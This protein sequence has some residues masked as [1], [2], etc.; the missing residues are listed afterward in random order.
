MSGARNASLIRAL[1]R[2]RF[3]LMPMEGA[4]GRA[5]GRPLRG[6]ESRHKL[7][8]DAGIEGT[9]LLG[10]ELLD[11]GFEI[12]PHLAARLVTDSAHLEEIVRW[13]E[14]LNV[15]EVFVIG[16]DAREPAG[17]FSSALELLSAMADVG[18]RFEQV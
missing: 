4:I 10:E 5:D 18:Q 8:A 2:P 1:S 17:Q 9:L 7:F 14:D 13:L 16:G 6:G 15:E 12:V 11:R 3:E